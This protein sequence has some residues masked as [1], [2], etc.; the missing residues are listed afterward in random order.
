MLD[1]YGELIPAPHRQKVFSGH[2]SI[3][4]W[5][6]FASG[7]RQAF[8]RL[9]TKAL[10]YLP[11]TRI[12]IHGEDVADREAAVFEV[13]AA[14]WSRQQ[15]Y[16]ASLRRQAYAQ[17]YLQLAWEYYHQNDLRGFRRCTACVFRYASPVVSLRLCVPFLKSF[18]GKNTADRLHAARKKMIPG[19]QEGGRT[20]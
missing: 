9:L 15:Q 2:C 12:F 17:Q 14:F 8:A 3:F 7:D 19:P 16:P 18:L 5:Q 6:Y 4:A 11:L 10:E 20:P 13:F 1:K